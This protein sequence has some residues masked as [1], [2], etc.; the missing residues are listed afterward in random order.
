MHWTVHNSFGV[1]AMN[2]TAVDEK[3]R[4]LLLLFRGKLVALCVYGGRQVWVGLGW[5][6]LW[7]GKKGRQ[8]AG[9]KTDSLYLPL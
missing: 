8:V 4:N 2:E 7:G 1:G 6:Y 9:Q 5:M 3:K